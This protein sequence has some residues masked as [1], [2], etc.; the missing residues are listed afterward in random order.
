MKNFTSG[1]SRLKVIFALF[2]DS[3]YLIRSRREMPFDP[4]DRTHRPHIGFIIISRFGFN[5][6]LGG[7]IARLSSCMTRRDYLTDSRCLPLSGRNP[8]FSSN[9]F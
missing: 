4:S 7:T 9:C 2:R 1:S 6:K 3:A 5:K 8:Q